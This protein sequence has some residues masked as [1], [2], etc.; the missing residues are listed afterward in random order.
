MGIPLF[1]GVQNQNYGVQKALAVTCDEHSPVHVFEILL[2]LVSIKKKK[3][4]KWTNRVGYPPNKNSFE[5]LYLIHTH[6]F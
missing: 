4:A 5:I 1:I 3:R 6:I 2:I